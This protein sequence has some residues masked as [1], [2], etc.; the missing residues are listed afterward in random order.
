[1]NLLE[2]QRMLLRNIKQREMNE[3]KLLTVSIAAY[4]A[5]KTLEEALLPFC[6]CKSREY[7][8]VLIIDDGSKDKTEEIGSTYATRY[9][10][11]IRVI[12]K[13]NGG[14]GSTLN[15]GIHEATGKY[16]KQLDA[17]DYYDSDT[18]DLFLEYLSK[19]DTDIVYSPFV[20][21]HNETGALLKELGVYSIFS[22]GSE[23]QLDDYPF[24]MPAMHTLTVKT[25]L[26]QKNDLSI[27]EHCFYTDLEFVFRCMTYSNTFSYFPWPLYYYRVAFEG[28]SMSVT[29]IRKHYLEHETVVKKCITLLEDVVNPKRYQTLFDRLAGACNLQYCF[30]CALELTHEHQNQIMEYDRWLKE[31]APSLYWTVSSRAITAMRKSKFKRYRLLGWIKNT[32]DRKKQRFVYEV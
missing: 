2:T 16:F 4:N 30:Y 5:E 3:M 19:V 6:N 20:M 7:L 22:E 10:S 13:K 9:P 12:S 24:F 18:L 1:M 15:V 25:E 11:V 23:Y 29:G 8:E 28:Q 26:L 32:M 14:W 31:T 27:T 17:D 21:F